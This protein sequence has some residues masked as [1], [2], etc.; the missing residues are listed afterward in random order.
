M[1]FLGYLIFRKELFLGELL[2]RNSIYYV[3]Y[4]ISAILFTLVL[5]TFILTIFN[6]TNIALALTLLYFLGSKF[7]AAYL[8]TIN[9]LFSK[10]DYTVVN[11]FNVI[12]K[13]LTI[14]IQS[15]PLNTIALFANILI[16]FLFSLIFNSLK[17]N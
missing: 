5:V 1:S 17:R 9:N 10:L 11:I 7:L 3:S 12:V 8:V 6:N 13:D 2:T 15:F 4:S 16:L 14:A